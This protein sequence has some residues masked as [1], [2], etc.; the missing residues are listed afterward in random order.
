MGS[1]KEF[2]MAVCSMKSVNLKNDTTKTLGTH[3]SNK[4]FT[5]K[6]GISFSKVISKI[7]SILTLWRMRNLALE[8]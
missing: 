6:K 4:K 3:F 7:Q 5:K 8:L 1:L 2:A